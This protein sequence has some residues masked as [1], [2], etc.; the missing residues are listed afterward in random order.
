MD[1]I[2]ENF[3]GDLYHA[4]MPG[5]YAKGTVTL[6]K[7]RIKI[8]PREAFLR[9]MDK[10]SLRS[11]SFAHKKGKK[12]IPV[13]SVRIP[14]KLETI[15]GKN[16]QLFVK[17]ERG[18]QMCTAVKVGWKIEWSNCHDFKANQLLNTLSFWMKNSGDNRYIFRGWLKE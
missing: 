11:T 15:E 6:E 18:F 1:R 5:F 4:A 3:Q 8:V 14:V 16:D 12:I 9:L 2:S 7:N 10:S 17:V 13:H